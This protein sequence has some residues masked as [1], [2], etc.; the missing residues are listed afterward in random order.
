[1]FSLFS[2]SVAFADTASSRVTVST[3]EDELEYYISA[4]PDGAMSVTS[5]GS[6]E[7]LTGS[8]TDN[9]NTGNTGILSNESSS[10]VT[11]D[12]ESYGIGYL[13]TDFIYNITSLYGVGSIGAIKNT[14]KIYSI[15][16]DFILNTAENTTNSSGAVVGLIS[17]GG[18]IVSIEGDFIS[19]SAATNRSSS[20]SSAAVNGFISNTGTISSIEANF[21]DNEL[22]TKAG[23]AQ[24]F[25]F[26][27]GTGTIGSITGNFS[28]N[29]STATTGKAYASAIRNAGTIYEVSGNFIA[30]ET[31]SNS[32]ANAYAGAV[33]NDGNIGFLAYDDGD[34][35]TDDNM[36][37]AGNTVNSVSNAIYNTGT[38]NFNAYNDCEISVNDGISGTTNGSTTGLIAINNVL[39]S[40]S[41][42]Y[43]SST[44]YSKVSFNNNVK[45]QTVTVYNGT[46]NL[47]GH[48]G[49]DVYT[50][51]TYTAYN[52]T[53]GELTSSTESY[54]TVASIASLTNTSI[55]VNSGATL[56]IGTNSSL[57]AVLVDGDSAITIKSGAEMLMD[58]SST[59][60][61]NY[62]ATL[63]FET[64]ITFTY[65]DASFDLALSAFV[66]EDEFSWTIFSF[67]DE[68]DAEALYAY[69]LEDGNL[70]ISDYDGE[71]LLSLSGSNIIFSNAVAV[72]EPST[73]AMIFGVIAL[74]FAY[75]RRRK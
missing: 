28:G 70:S 45:N 29:S 18:T 55:T 15:D 64:N 26:N 61:L 59:L 4:S 1:M 27:Q 58:A 44:D 17:N 7:K 6:I 9:S 11:I 32:A 62:G 60:S 23:N 47:G 65:T 63:T 74:G 69:L 34:S 56:Q 3:E 19:N 66:A 24:G 12:D 48:N 68:S 53:T 37:F 10:G 73:Y 67:A 40:D 36:T 57:D 75:Y 39:T 22:S 5:T 2:A 20:S 50:W 41:Y 33:Y 72:P 46:L 49:G 30:N 31:A 14:G 51:D 52:T 43:Y 38:V 13:E 54:T 21:S 16:A 71:Y 35:S 8:F 42:D 25:L